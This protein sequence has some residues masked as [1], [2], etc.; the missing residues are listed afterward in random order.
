M[1]MLKD[2]ELY[3]MGIDDQKE[4]VTKT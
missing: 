1:R 4:L 2:P 3:N